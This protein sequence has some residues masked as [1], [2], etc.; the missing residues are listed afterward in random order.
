MKTNQKQNLKHL[1]F[2]IIC[3]VLINLTAGS[4]IEPQMPVGVYGASEQM[5]IDGGTIELV[6]V[7]I[8]GIIGIVHLIVSIRNDRRHKKETKALTHEIT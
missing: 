6:K 3:M 7:I 5:P 2:T 1:I 4:Q 8:Q